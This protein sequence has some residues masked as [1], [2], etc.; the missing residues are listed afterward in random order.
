MKLKYFIPNIILFASC[1]NPVSPTGGIKDTQGP[2]IIDTIIKKSSNNNQI[3]LLFDENIQVQNN[4]YF[5]PSL[6]REPKVKIT[7][8]TRKVIIPFKPYHKTLI[9][10]N[11]IKDLNEGN[12][13]KSVQISVNGNDTLIQ[14][15]PLI[16]PKYFDQ[17]KKH[18]KSHVIISDSLYY[19]STLEKDTIC[20]YGFPDTV[21]QATIYID[22]NKDDKANPTE[23][24]TFNTIFKPTIIL[25]PPKRTNIIIDTTYN[26]PL[27][28]APFYWH[29]R[30][31][32]SNNVDSTLLLEKIKPYSGDTCIITTSFYK[33]LISDTL[34]TS[35]KYKKLSQLPEY[36]DY[37]TVINKDTIRELVEIPTTR[38]QNKSFD[39]LSKII[40]K[41][42]ISIQ[43]PD[44]VN[45]IKLTI[46]KNGQYYNN[47]IITRDTVNLDL[48]QGTYTYIAISHKTK[49]DF[50]YWTPDIQW[51]AYFEEFLVKPG[52]DNVISIG[53]P[54]KKPGFSSGKNIPNIGIPSNVKTRVK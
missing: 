8:D 35:I 40:K 46:L 11:S 22:E 38:N 10:L 33:Y 50:D 1:A 5:N 42:S 25:L 34:F 39:T 53:Y 48:E 7:K 31:K 15:N 23:W 18:T 29:Q 16:L 17:L 37:T 24:Q 21:T 45:N 20:Y 43:K 52:I 32:K 26:H 49:T 9:F 13:L 19:R 44:T 14:R 2:I 41:G 47:I 4:F 28:V 51:L 12:I 6:I 36:I 54:V 27:V 3:T 30:N